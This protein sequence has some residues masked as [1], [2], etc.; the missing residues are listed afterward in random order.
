MER[1]INCLECKGEDYKIIN[2]NHILIHEGHIIYD[3]VNKIYDVTIL[4]DEHYLEK[5][6]NEVIEILLS[7]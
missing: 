2:E 4:D 1:I 7:Y 3:F 5:D 6:I